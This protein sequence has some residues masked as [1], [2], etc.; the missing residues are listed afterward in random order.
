MDRE[1]Q[2][3]KWI[4]REILPHERSARSRLSRRWANVLEIDDVIQE[5][6]CRIARLD[7]VHHIANPVG[8]FHRTAHAV[9]IDALRRR[10]VVNLVQVN[11]SEWLDVKDEEPLADRALEARQ[12]LARATGLLAQL[13]DTCRRAIE[14]RRLE[15]FSQRETAEQLGVSESVVRNHL[16]RGVHKVLKAL[17]SE[18]DGPTEASQKP[19]ETRVEYIGTRRSR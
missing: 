1:G 14:M 2:I 8:Y 3:A 10:G 17:A 16:V 18:D 5:A 12:E 19:V 9:A 7:A 4:A 11:E 6:Y 15:G 13:S